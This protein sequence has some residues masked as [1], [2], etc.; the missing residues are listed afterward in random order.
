MFYA[1]PEDEAAAVRRA[2]ARAG[3]T[4]RTVRVDGA[5]GA[6]GAKVVGLVSC[7]DGWAAAKLLLAM[8]EEDARTPGARELAAQLRASHPSDQDFAQ[9]VQRYVQRIPFVREKGEVFQSGALTMARGA[10]DCDDHFRLVYALARAGGLRGALA[11]TH[12]GDDAPPAKRGPTHAA[13]M[14]DVGGRRE[15]AETTVPAQWGEHPFAAARRLGLLSMRDDV[16]REVRVMTPEDDLMPIPE[17]FRSR[18]D[19]AQVALD[20]EALQRLGFLAADAVFDATDPGDPTLRR[21][22]HAFQCAV[23]IAADGLLGPVTRTEIARSLREAGPPI[24]Q[25]L[26][27]PGGSIGDLRTPAPVARLSKHLSDDFMRAVVAMAEDFR[28]LGAQVTAED[29]FKVWLAESGIDSHRP[30]GQGAPFGGLNQMGPDERKAAGFV[31]TFADWLALDPLSQLPFVRRYYENAV[32]GGAGGDF[33]VLRDA[34]SLYLVNAAPAFISH[35]GDPE[36]VIFRRDPK[37]PEVMAPESEWAAW[38]NAHR[39][40]PYAWNRGLDTNKDG[41]IRVTE[42]GA[43]LDGATRGSAAYWDEVRAR[44]TALGGGRAP[45]GGSGVAVLAG[46]VVLAGMAAGA[47][48]AVRS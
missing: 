11:L 27:Y 35:A 28:T 7:V 33:R 36:F 21:A 17:G 46:L 32:R 26:G 38:R 39:S 37:G 29:F 5:G 23:G 25:G 44:V 16:A 10:G 22:V 18:N 3:C 1:S 14:L 48:Y 45:G 42:L 9:A 19:P 15:W 13:A 6:Y 31:G 8:A 40:D 34:P 30:N 41:T 4:L 20:A 12:H 2:V 47:Y 24:N 43:V